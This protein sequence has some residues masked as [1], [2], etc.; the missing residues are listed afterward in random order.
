MIKKVLA[1]DPGI[2]SLGWA[3]TEQNEK[4]EIVNLID[5]GSIIFTSVKENKGGHFKN[6]KR[7]DRRSKRRNQFRSNRR[8][9]K[10]ENYLINHHFLS[11]K[12]NELSDNTGLVQQIVGNPYELRK[13]ALDEPLTNSELGWAIM[14]L[15][16][17]RGF[18]SSSKSLT[19]EEKRDQ[20]R[21]DEL[22]TLMLKNKC[23]TLGEYFN[24]LFMSNKKIRGEKLKRQ[25]IQDELSII[26]ENQ[27]QYNKA[28]TENFISEVNEIIFNQRP[29]KI[30]KRISICK[31]ESHGKIKKHTAAKYHPLSQQL[32]IWGVI[33]NLKYTFNGGMIELTLKQKNIIFNLLW[34]NKEI[35]YKKIIKELKL[36]SDTNFNFQKNSNDKVQGNQLLNNF[37]LPT[38][39]WFNSLSEIDKE[40]LIVEVATITDTTGKALQKRLYQRWTTDLDIIDNLLLSSNKLPQGYT[41]FCLKSTKKILSY[42]KQGQIYSIAEKSAYPNFSIAKNTN[43]KLPPVTG[44]TNGIVLKSCTQVRHLI[45]ALIEKYGEID[46]IKIELA[47]DLSKSKEQLS[48][49]NINNF[50]NKKNNDEAKNYLIK[51]NININHNNIIKYKLWKENIDSDGLC[52]SSYP[53]KNKKGKW[54]FPSINLSDLYGANSAYEIEHIIPKSISGDDSY[55]NKALCS[56]KINSLKGKQTPYDYYFEK[57]GQ[58]LVDEIAKKSYK[59]FGKNKGQKFAISTQDY[60]NNNPIETRFLNDTRYISIFLKEYLQSVCKEEVVVSKG[61]FTAMI[62]QSLNF[63]ALLGNDFVKNRGDHRHHMVDAFCTSIISPNIL[64]TLDHMRK[65]DN[66]KTIKYIECENKLNSYIKNVKQDFLEHFNKVITSHEVETRLKGELEEETLYGHDKIILKNGAILEKLFNHKSFEDI[67]KGKDAKQ[68]LEDHKSYKISLPESLIKRLK[69]QNKIPKIYNGWKRI[70]SYYPELATTDSNGDII[71]YRTVKDNNK[72]IGY[73]KTDSKAYTIVYKDYSNEAITKMNAVN[74]NKSDNILLKLYRGD[75]LQNEDGNIFKIYQLPKGQVTIHPV[76]LI[77][78]EGRDA[79]KNDKLIPNSK[80][81]LIKSL[82]EKENYKKIKVDILGHII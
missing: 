29:L 45:N 27:K 42:L 28:I 13:K 47:R 77:K 21:A 2:T 23:R 17:R 68:L 11:T 10:L 70:K 82:F 1:L 80:V 18:L 72:I 79:K 57:G 62:R 81:K 55:S 39:K 35:T 73:K 34:E 33:N 37:K 4:G 65:E 7:R 36:N 66:K 41:A 22:S 15:A 71:G 14:H 8:M 56:H 49:I 75:L 76:N 38:K 54:I 30:Q 67:T 44:I 5:A 3:L 64:N 59:K 53:E 9:S 46:V 69:S 74:N 61:G 50:K 43:I 26:L 12:I 16:K 19:A 48:Q 51:N 24:I 6:E 63:N 60:L 31:F 52:E 40:T 78:V 20:A 32:I 25:L 58:S